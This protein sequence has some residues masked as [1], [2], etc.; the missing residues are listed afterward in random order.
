M[1]DLISEQPLLNI[2]SVIVSGVGTPINRTSFDMHHLLG[3]FR[4]SLIIP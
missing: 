4:F 3:C 1:K 2:V